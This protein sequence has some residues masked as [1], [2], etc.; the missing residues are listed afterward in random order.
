[1]TDVVLTPAACYPV[2]P[3]LPGTL[4]ERGRLVDVQNRV[5]PPRA[6]GRPGAHADVPH[7][8][9][10]ARRRARGRARVARR[11]GSSA[12]LALLRLARAR[13]PGADAPPTTRSS[14]AA[15]GCSP[16]TSASRSSSSSSWSDHLAEKPTAICSFN[17]HQDTSASCSTSRLPTASVAHTACLGFGLERVALALFKTHGLDP[18][19]WPAAV[20]ER[21]WTDDRRRAP[22]ARSAASYAR[23]ALHRRRPRLAGD[24]LLRRPVDRGAARLGPRPA[25][26][27][28]GF[29][30]D[31][32][33][34]GDQW[35]FFKPPHG[36][37]PA[38]YG[39]DVQELN[40]WRPLL[41]HVE[42]QSPRGGWCWPRSTRSTCPTP[43]APTT[44]RQHTKTTIGIQAHRRP[45]ASGWGTSTTPATSSSTGEDFAR[46]VPARRAGRRRTRLPLYVE[47]VAA[48]APAAAAARGSCVA[49]GARVLPGAPRGA[50]RA[51]TRWR[52]SRRASPTPI[53]PASS[54][55]ARRPTT[56]TPS[57]PA[58]ARRRVRARAHH[59]RWLAAT[60]ERPLEPAAAALRR[61]IAVA[62]K[63]L[64]P[65][66]GARGRHGEARSTSP[67]CSPR[68][69]AAGARRST[70]SAPRWARGARRSM[71]CIQR[72]AGR[73]VRPGGRAGSSLAHRAGAAA[74]PP[75]RWT[76]STD[77]WI[78]PRYPGRWPARSA[79]RGRGP[80]RRAA[81]STPTTG[82]YRCRFR[83]AP[84][85]RGSVA[86]RLEGLA[87]VAE[88]WLNGD[89]APP[90]RATCSQRTGSTSSR[91]LRARERA[92]TC[93]SVAL[94][95]LLAERRPRPRWKT[96]LVEQQQLRWFR[97][98]LLGRI[99]GWTPAGAAGRTVP[100]GARSSTARRPDRCLGAQRADAVAGDVGTLGAALRTGA[101]QAQSSAPSSRL[102]GPARRRSRSLERADGTSGS[103]AR[104][105]S[106][107]SRAGGR[108]RTARRRSTALSV[109]ARR[110]GETRSSCGRVG[111]RTPRGERR[112]RRLRAARQ[113][114][115][116]C[117]A[118]APAGRRSTSS[119]ST[120]A[121]G[122]L[123]ARARA[124]AR[125]RA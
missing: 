54:R 68:W 36:D 20:R 107:R 43:R 117:S 106:R 38:L 23:H 22:A 76:R 87:T 58:P 101:S 35:T 26:L 125:R 123:R 46:A 84:S 66:G 56:C 115:A 82:W 49:L 4:P 30:L 62:A 96:R 77:A 119:R 53:W 24:Q 29:T 97:T 15:G 37:L 94:G 93:A 17:Y 70:A 33:F 69:P 16:P 67:R 13:R 75:P 111:F 124:G 63:A 61:G 83:G 55:G 64:H 74:T 60:G 11:R 88:V 9:V 112:R 8:R 59:L 95:P 52:A 2:Y 28:C 44:G 32:D 108:T 102:G 86:L 99:P 72:T 7:A 90:L 105:S 109:R 6:L 25:G 27:P 120:R 104:S 80:R 116:R 3:T 48:R 57:P 122:E 1:M 31:L 100:A 39:V 91:L 40:I 45:S 42:E 103:P 10:R 73:S 41:D 21:L 47:F 34:E 78:R 19:E 118:G 5:L 12:A 81:T 110:R 65:Q 71:A 50:G 92:R 14:A 89:A 121:R 98:T 113:R 85:R 18:A 79:P 114:R 51:R